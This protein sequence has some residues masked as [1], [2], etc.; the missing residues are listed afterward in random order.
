MSDPNLTDINI[1]RL[2]MKYN[3]LKTS[4]ASKFRGG[5]KKLSGKFLLYEKMSRASWKK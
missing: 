1:P 5:A 3:D 2:Q 4:A